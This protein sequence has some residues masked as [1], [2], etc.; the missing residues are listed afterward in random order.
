M[1]EDLTPIQDTDNNLASTQIESPSSDQNSSLEDSTVLPQENNNKPCGC[2]GKGGSSI[3]ASMSR[4]F[5]YAVGRIEPTFPSRGSE[6]EYLQA[7][8]RIETK[9]QTDFGAMRTALSKRENRYLVR[10]LCWV[11]RIEGLETYILTPRDPGDF[12]MLVD[13]LRVPPR[14]TDIDLV[15]GMRGPLATAEMC[16]GLVVPIVLFDQIYSFDIDSLTKAIPR[17]EKADAKKFSAVAEELFNRMV[18]IADNVGATDEHRALN[19]LS[20]RYDSIYADAAEMHERD[21]SLSAVEVRLS[22]LSGTRKVVD[23]IFAYR[24]RNTDFI[25]KHFVRVDV[26]EEF[27]YLVNKL[28]PYYER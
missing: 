4:S 22:R 8:G 6:N 3:D 25:E 26:T 7:V 20:V 19:Y 18:Q 24:N 13:A 16:N 28:S 14:G 12:E 15:V 10:Q 17:P 27:P 11:L 23:V 21:F 1:S 2:G 5:I 9:G